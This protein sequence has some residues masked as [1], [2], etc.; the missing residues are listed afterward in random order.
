[1]KH[2]YKLNT[3]FVCYKLGARTCI[4]N[5]YMKQLKITPFNPVYFLKINFSC[6][7]TCLQQNLLSCTKLCNILIYIL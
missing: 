5:K 1:M 4:A 7:P 2:S 6:L 3:E